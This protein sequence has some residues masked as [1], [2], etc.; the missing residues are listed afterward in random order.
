L[1]RDPGQADAGVVGAVVV[2]GLQATPNGHVLV[3]D[4]GEKIESGGY[5]Y[6]FADTKTKNPK[7]EKLRSHGRYPRALSTSKGSWP[8]AMSRVIKP[9]RIRGLLTT[10]WRR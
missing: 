9:F 10:N 8:G 2:G 4:P 7:T 5:L 6:T 3:I 1:N